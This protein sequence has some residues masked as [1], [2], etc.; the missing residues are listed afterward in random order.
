MKHKTLF[1]KECRKALK[2]INKG[3]YGHPITQMLMCKDW[4]PGIGQL[5]VAK[6]IVIKLAKWWKKFDLSRDEFEKFLG[7]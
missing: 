4:H 1:K 6:R 2:R 5:A 7:Y 3:D